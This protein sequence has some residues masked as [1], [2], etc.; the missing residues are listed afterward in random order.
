ML[1]SLLILALVAPGC[2]PTPAE[3]KLAGFV[4]V[5]GSSTVYPITEAVAE[6]FIKLHP[7]VKVTV[8][9]SGTGGGFKKFCAGETDINDASR[10][11]KQKESEACQAKGIEWIEL[12]VAFDGI[13][14][15]VNPQ[16]DWVECLTVEELKRLWEP[17]SPVKKWSDLRP[18]WPD[19]EIRLY[20]PDTDSGTFDYFTEAIVGEEDASRADYTASAD[21]YMLV[22]GV[23]WDKY[24][25]GYFG[26]AYYAENTD[27]LRAVA[28]DAGEG[29]IAPSPETIEGGKYKSLSRPLFIYVSKE[30]LQR[31]EVEAFVRFYLT[32]GV[33][34]I[35]EVGYVPLGDEA[36]DE[37]L[38]ALE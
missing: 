27:K 38:D 22:H 5:D 3:V 15:V 34:L 30:A 8:G 19:E 7:D 16:N 33:A 24:G 14:V 17:A 36:Y 18:E 1:T 35:L 12:K 31:P 28:I 23:A 6:E 10:P 13:S 25:L 2:R 21:D 9:V 32:E 26:Y 29:C 11:I 20:G 37:A 4:R